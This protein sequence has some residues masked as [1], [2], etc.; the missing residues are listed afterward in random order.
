MFW[1]L[2]KHM[3]NLFAPDH[4]LIHLVSVLSDTLFQWPSHHNET[5]MMSMPTESLLV[6]YIDIEARHL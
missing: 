2:Y 1:G 6:L 5:I 4:N 3:W